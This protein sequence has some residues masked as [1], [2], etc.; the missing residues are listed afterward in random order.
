[1]VMPFVLVRSDRNRSQ[2]AQKE[3]YSMEQQ[4]LLPEYDLI[5]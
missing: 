4:L 1:M 5:D 2:S 3:V